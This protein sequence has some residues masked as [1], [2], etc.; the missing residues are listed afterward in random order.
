MLDTYMKENRIAPESDGGRELLSR[1]GFGAPNAKPVTGPAKSIAKP[2]PDGPPK[3]ADSAQ[4]KWSGQVALRN[5]TSDGVIAVTL[6]RAPG[7]M[8]ATFLGTDGNGQGVAMKTSQYKG[9]EGKSEALQQKAL[10]EE[11]Q[12]LKQAAS[13][14]G[15]DGFPTNVSVPEVLGLG[16]MDEGLAA[17]IYGEAQRV[18]VLMMKRM[19]G[20]T[21]Q[22]WLA[23]GRNLN[24]DDYRG[25]VKAVKMLH[26]NGLAHGDLNMGNI[27][28]YEDP[29]TGKQSFSLL[30]FG[31]SKAH[32][33]VDAGLYSSIKSDDTKSLLDIAGYFK[34]KGKLVQN[35]GSSRP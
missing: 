1:Y 17:K 4:S 30:D 23:K 20:T 8:E 7:N 24:I 32:S 9:I 29:A 33:A 31:A 16:Y 19:Q 2:F 34:E 35:P 22:D 5:G 26:E 3:V 27:L 18:P 13:V 28:I 11:A 14:A 25:L 6:D 12:S 15:K 21:I 10:V